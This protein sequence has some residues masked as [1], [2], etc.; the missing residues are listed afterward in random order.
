MNNE[1]LNLIEKIF[2][3]ILSGSPTEMIIKSIFTI[4]VL[5]IVAYLAIKVI[6]SKHSQFIGNNSHNN[7]QVG[8]DYISKKD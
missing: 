7:T 5:I 1:K 2:N 3:L 6:K 8:R 4:L